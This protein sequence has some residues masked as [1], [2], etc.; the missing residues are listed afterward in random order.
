MSK[1][2]AVTSDGGFALWELWMKSHPPYYQLGWSPAGKAAVKA[3]LRP[4]A[5]IIAMFAMSVQILQAD[6]AVEVI[7]A[8]KEFESVPQEFEGGRA[9]WADNGPRP[10]DGSRRNISIKEKH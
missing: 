4:G 9:P 2:A 6:G 5:K 7:E 8:D 10:E 1:E 3:A